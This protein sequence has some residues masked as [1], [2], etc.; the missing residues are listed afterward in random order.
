MKKLLLP[1][2]FFLAGNIY[3]QR[4]QST[5]LGSVTLDDLQM[6][7]Y[8]KDSSA[9]AVILNEELNK[10]YTDTKRRLYTTN[11]YRKLKVLK[12][13][14]L[15][16]GT[17]KVRFHFR[18]KV[19]L[20]KG[21]CYNLGADGKMVKNVIKKE[22]IITTKEG[23]YITHIL[24]LSNVKVGSVIE[25]NYRFTNTFPL[26]PDWYF[27]KDIPVKKST[28]KLLKPNK[29]QYLVNLIGSQPLSSQERIENLL[30][31]PQADKDEKCTYTS[32]SMVDVPKYQPEFLSP[33]PNLLISK[34]NF[35]MQNYFRLNN[36]KGW[37]GY[38]QSQ[39]GYYLREEKQNQRLFRKS[40]PEDL[41]IAN[42]PLKTA[43]NI[44]YF[45]QNKYKWNRTFSRDLGYS[46]KKKSKQKEVSLKLIVTALYSSLRSV[47]IECHYVDVSTTSLGPIDTS[48]PD[49]DDFNYTI[50]KAIINGKSYFLDATKKEL[51][52]GYIQ[53]FATTKQ[54]RV[55]DF[56]KG[57]YWSK[58]TQPKPSSKT[59]T[60][61]MKYEQG[62]GFTGTIKTQSSGYEAVN[63]RTQ[64][65]ELGI[66]RYTEDLK[67]ETENY[68]LV[69]YAIDHLDN[70]EKP[71]TENLEIEIEDDTEDG[72]NI[73]LKPILFQPLGQSPFTNKIRKYPVDFVYPRVYSYRINLKIPKGFKVDKLP[74]N[75]KFQLNNRGASYIYMTKLEGDVLKIF[76]SLKIIK[77]YHTTEEYEDLKTLFG[78]ILLAEKNPIEF[79]K[80][81]E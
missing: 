31:T 23:N 2:L 8:E 10:Y 33:H 27:Q 35:R 9:V 37:E 22:N 3:G 1:L 47:G 58:V 72:E 4:S 43:K 78:Q 70:K 15:E 80:I 76:T 64:I 59:S 39:K 62:L 18:T 19:N 66:T 28:I 69:K 5:Q 60:I 6:T 65:N 73:T 29:L 50:I 45:V 68:D 40:I 36:K 21:I 48:K 63:K 42:N 61:D 25:I 74:E 34:L 12:N 32:Y 30:C 20:L 17:Y 81:N 24:N 7:V 56:D 52:F 26:A 77:T 55:L 11:Y 13:D 46:T 44:F 51:E 67:N 14:G 53:T 54:V 79:K 16:Y 71:F 41:I 75:K 57:G 38:D 49:S